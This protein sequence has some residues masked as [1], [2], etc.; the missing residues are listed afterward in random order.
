MGKGKGLTE[1][2]ARGRFRRPNET[3]TSSPTACSQDRRARRQ[4]AGEHPVQRWNA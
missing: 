3:S 4:A 2:Q 1:R